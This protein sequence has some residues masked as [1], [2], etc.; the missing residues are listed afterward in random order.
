MVATI[1]KAIEGVKGINFHAFAWNGGNQRLDIT[2]IDRLNEVRSI[3]TEGIGGTPT[4]EAMAYSV[5]RL[6]QMGGKHKVLIFIT[7]GS[8]NNGMTGC[9]QVRKWVN[10]ATK[11]KIDV[12]GVYTGGSTYYSDQDNWAMSEMFGKGNYMVFEDMN[13]SATL[14]IS[15]FKQF[16]MKAVRK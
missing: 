15:K 14:V 6:K 5:A 13:K 9:K 16:A 3:T 8:P 10:I 12:I 2:E 7:D 1:F 11:D 4:P